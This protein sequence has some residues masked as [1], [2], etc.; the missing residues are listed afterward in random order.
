M[1]LLINKTTE[2]IQEESIP[3]SNSKLRS[4]MKNYSFIYVSEIIDSEK[5]TTLLKKIKFSLIIS[6]CLYKESDNFY[7]IVSF[8][9]TV[10]IIPKKSLSFLENLLSSDQN[11]VICF[12]NDDTK[13]IFDSCIKVNYEETK[14]IFEDDFIDKCIINKI[15]FSSKFYYQFY[16]IWLKKV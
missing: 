16:N 6:I 11:L 3:I 5:I 1:D 9:Q 2:F 7:F 15:K 10:L 13:S 4:I 8:E 14:L 12:S